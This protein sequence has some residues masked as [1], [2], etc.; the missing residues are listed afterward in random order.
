[1]GSFNQNER[2][3]IRMKEFLQKQFL[4]DKKFG[5]MPYFWMIALLLFSIQPI[6]QAQGWAR[7]LIILLGLIFAK[8]YH[9]S[10]SYSK[11]MD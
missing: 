1:M 6:L 11:Y 5:F 10:Y 9:D 2:A 4:F 7:W 8:L 3:S